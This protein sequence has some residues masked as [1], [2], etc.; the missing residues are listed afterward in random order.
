MTKPFNTMKRK[1]I[2]APEMKVIFLRQYPVVMGREPK[3]KARWTK[4]AMREWIF[5]HGYCEYSNE[6]IRGQAFDFDHKIPRALLEEGDDV[7]WQPLLKKWHKIKTAQDQKDIARAKRRAGETG[8]L[9]RR[10]ARGYSLIQGR[11]EFQQ[12]PEGHNHF[13]KPEGHKTKWPKRKVGQ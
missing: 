2:T 1:P 13:Y 3:R 6:P 5:N 10:K 4:K 12:A 9:K 11:S 7:V 8:Q